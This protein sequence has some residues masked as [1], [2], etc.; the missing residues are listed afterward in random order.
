MT[1]RVLQEEEVIVFSTIATAELV[2]I[3]GIAS[4]ISP[5]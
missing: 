2:M 5:C 3:Q 4:H 1:I